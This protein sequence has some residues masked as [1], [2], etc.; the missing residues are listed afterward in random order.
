MRTRPNFGRLYQM[1]CRSVAH[2]APQ[3]SRVGGRKARGTRLKGS[4]SRTSEPVALQM[5][6]AVGAVEE[7]GDAPHPLPQCT[8]IDAVASEHDRL[9]FAVM[10]IAKGRSWD[11][12]RE[13]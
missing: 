9:A 11:Q 7:I 3:S 8:H 13:K 4:A 5:Q 2:S 10:R 1:C 6:L 12:S